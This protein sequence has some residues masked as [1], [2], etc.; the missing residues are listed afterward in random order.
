MVKLAVPDTP[1]SKEILANMLSRTPPETGLD[2]YMTGPS[3]YW[4]VYDDEN[5]SVGYV[6]IHSVNNATRRCRGIVWI[7]PDERR[8]GYALEAVTVRNDMLFDQF[9]FNRIEWAVSQDNRVSMEFSE[10]RNWA[11]HEGTLEEG[12][13]Y[14]GKYHDVELYAVTRRRR[15]LNNDK[16]NDFTNPGQGEDP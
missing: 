6:G 9:N 5:V 13:Y 8:K 7:E 11:H 2:P 10:K 1:I 15:D 14:D 4:L 16:R 3:T 12:M